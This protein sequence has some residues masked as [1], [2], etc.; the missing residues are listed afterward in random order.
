MSQPNVS[1]VIPIRNEAN[2]I[3]TCLRSFLAQTYPSNRFEVIV[4]D[5]RSS[6]GSRSTVE[7]LCKEHK[8]V[9]CLDNPA[10]TA[11]CGMNVGIRSARGEII[12]R[13]DGHN[14]YPP[15][16][17]ENCV[18]YLEE[19][20][21]DNV[22]GP[23][24][25]VPAN[26]SFGARM[27][28]AILTSPFG[29]GDSKFRISSLEGYVETVPFGAFRRELFDRIGMYNEKLVRNQDNELNARIREAGGKI[30]QTP[31]LRTEYHPVAGFRKFLKVT[32]KTSQWHLFSISEN[33]GAMSARHFA[34]ALFV[35]AIASLACRSAF[36]HR[37][38]WL[39]GGLLGLYL[40]AG[41]LTALVRSRKYGWAIVAAFPLACLMFHI[42]YGLGTLAGT[43]YLFTSPPSS[44]IREGLPTT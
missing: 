13:A 29:V 32:F 38:L 20:G 37:A 40:C 43:R 15:D 22:G 3:L 2:Y 10:G 31:A 27:V 19:T 9:Q 7:D 14:F 23:W 4:V 11:P 33:G 12:V 26:N 5:G 18:K 16:Y 24:L 34:P 41:I 28:A 30:Y 25:T 36:A 17:I 1:V 35:I 8:N 44:P 39:L 6:D 42:S 21:A